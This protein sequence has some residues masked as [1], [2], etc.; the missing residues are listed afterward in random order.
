MKKRNLNADLIRCTA[1]FCVVSVHFLL[2]TGLQCGNERDSD[3]LH[4]YGTVS[5]YGMRAAV[6]DFIR[7]PD[8]AE[9]AV[10]VLLQGNYQNSGDLR[11]G[12]YRLP[13]F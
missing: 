5:F 3:A 13:A 2:N 6:H 10:K 4:V 9:A 12:Q 7:L 11:S 1:A 8:V